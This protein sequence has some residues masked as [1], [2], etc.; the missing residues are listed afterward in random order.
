MN[1]TKEEYSRAFHEEERALLQRRI[2]LFGFVTGVTVLG[3]LVVRV[4]MAAFVPNLG[5]DLAIG[6]NAFAGLALVAGWLVCRGNPLST[7]TLRVIETV[8]TLGACV[9]LGFMAIELPHAYSPEFVLVA[10]LGIVIVA[11]AIYVP[12]SARHTLLLTTLIGATLA[13]FIWH[14][15][16]GFDVEAWSHVHPPFGQSSPEKLSVGRTIYFTVCGPAGS[17]QRCGAD[18]RYWSLAFRHQLIRAVSRSTR[19]VAGIASSGGLVEPALI[20]KDPLFR[21]VRIER[22]RAGE[23]HCHFAIERVSAASIF[24]GY[25]GSATAA[26]LA[27]LARCVERVLGAH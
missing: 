10:G 27:D 4:L 5:Y 12:S 18:H 7:R 25:G 23:A 14:L 26:L 20:R 16:L 22:R 9:G 2:G 21:Y 11:R 3:F 17:H 15:N 1:K 19:S 6:G 24:S 13:A 8:S